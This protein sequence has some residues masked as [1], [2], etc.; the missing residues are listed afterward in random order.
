MQIPVMCAAARFLPEYEAKG[1]RSGFVCAQVNPARAGDRDCMYAMAKR[2]HAWSPN[3]AVKLP[4]TAAG[5]D[6][7][8]DC[9]AE[10]ITTTATVSFTVPQ[11]LAIAER[12]RAGSRRAREKGIEPGQCFAVIMIGTAGRLS[13]RYRPRQP[14]ARERIRHPPGGAGRHEAGLP[15]LPGAGLRGRPAGGGV[16]RCISYDGTGGG[17]PVDVDSPHAAG[18]VCHAGPAAR[19]TN[20]PAG[21]PRC[22]GPA[23]GRCRSSCAPSNRMV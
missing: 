13:P 9:A 11:V 4:A 17:R 20:R 12:H 10:G 5:L 21:R 22:G 2:F 6:V 1:G 15:N 14:R 7:L 8:E 18:M 23:C 16:A 19:G 3:I